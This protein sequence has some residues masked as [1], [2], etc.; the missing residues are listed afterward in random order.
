MIDIFLYNYT[1][2]LFICDVTSWFAMYEL[3]SYYSNE[4]KT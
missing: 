3:E 1:M 4:I 2:I